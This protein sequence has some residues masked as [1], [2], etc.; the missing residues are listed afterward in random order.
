VAAQADLTL[1]DGLHPT[2]EG[3]GIIVKR[4]LPHVKTLIANISKPAS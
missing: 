2:A 4:I 3:I 1:P